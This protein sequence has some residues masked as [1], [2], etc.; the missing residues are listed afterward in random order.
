MISFIS[1]LPLSKQ[2]SNLSPTPPE[3]AAMNSTQPAYIFSST[4]SLNQ[5]ISL[6]TEI[7]AEVYASPIYC[8]ALATLTKNTK[9]EK[10]TN[11]ILKKITRSVIRVAFQRFLTIPEFQRQPFPG[12]PFELSTPSIS[13]TPK[14]PMTQENLRTATMPSTLEESQAQSN[15][16]DAKI[17]QTDRTAQATQG[18]QAIADS[19]DSNPPNKFHNF[20]NKAK[21]FGTKITQSIEFVGAEP[22]QKELAFNLVERKKNEQE[23]QQKRLQEIGEEIRSARLAKSISIA[24]IS[25]KTAILS[26]KVEAIENGCLEKLPEEIYIQGYIRRL[27]Q[28]VGLDGDRLANYLLNNPP[29][30]LENKKKYDTKNTEPTNQ[31]KKIY[32][33]SMHLFWVYISL[34]ASSVGLLSLIVNRTDAS[35]NLPEEKTKDSEC[36][37]ITPETE[38]YTP[39]KYSPELTPP[40]K[41]ITANLSISPPE[42]F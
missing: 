4:I 22:D 3:E 38:K 34:I 29:N 31:S 25:L 8:N 30:H 35:T 24:Q 28:A 21:E 5:M 20:V 7:E 27:G 16:E 41:T 11:S 40:E 37:P 19:S 26:S 10:N 15:R 17:A 1:H 13:N 33:N 39:K 2:L 36:L 14:E 18:A 23:Q 6:V 32:L 12:Q 9:N 42:T